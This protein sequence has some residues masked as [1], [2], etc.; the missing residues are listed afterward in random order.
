MLLPTRLTKNTSPSQKWQ[1]R[2]LVMPA[3]SGRGGARR[4]AGTG[5]QHRHCKGLGKYLSPQQLRRKGARAC[6]CAFFLPVFPSSYP[7]L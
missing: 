6:V 1:T 5:S 2:D 4:G 3:T 7:Y